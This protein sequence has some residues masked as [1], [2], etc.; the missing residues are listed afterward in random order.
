MK[1]SIGLGLTRFHV[2]LGMNVGALSKNANN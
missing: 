2:V 1:D